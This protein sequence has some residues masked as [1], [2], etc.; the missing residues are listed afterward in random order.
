MDRRAFFR[1][2]ALVLPALLGGWDTGLAIRD[3]RS[4]VR[5]GLPSTQWRE[6]NGDVVTAREIEASW[7][8]AES[9]MTTTLDRVQSELVAKLYSRPNP[10]L[11]E[12]RW[13]S[14]SS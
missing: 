13:K 2:T 12:L 11:Q 8:E 3:W 5:T 14:A 10:L 1:R 4:V 7:T 9:R 6:L